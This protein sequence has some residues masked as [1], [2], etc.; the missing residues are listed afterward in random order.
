MATGALVATVVSTIVSKVM[1]G[2]HANPDVAGSDATIKGDKGDKGDKGEKGDPGPGTKGDKGDPGEKG[3][4]GDKG[5]KGDPGIASPV[6]LFSGA[7]Y[8]VQ[9]L[10]Y[11]ANWVANSGSFTLSPAE[12]VAYGVTAP[13]DRTITGIAVLVP[14]GKII[15]VSVRE[16]AGNGSVGQELA[17]I[18]TLQN[19]AQGVSLDV[20][21]ETG[22]RYYV[23]ISCAE[24]VTFTGFAVRPEATSMLNLNGSDSMISIDGGQTWDLHVSNITPRIF[25]KVS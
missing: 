10:H 9:P 1:L 5:D 19:M 8:G 18:T 11:P 7:L 17:V 20:S 24:S 16:R 23:V 14:A 6:R 22:R 4:K 2:S 12:T 21:L 3:E 15:T 25:F 13:V